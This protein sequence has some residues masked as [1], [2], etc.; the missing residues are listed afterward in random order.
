MGM[1]DVMNIKKNPKNEN[2]YDNFSFLVLHKPLSDA[3]SVCRPSMVT[4]LI[5]GNKD[6]YNQ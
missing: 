6:Q 2:D 5:A 3:F 4:Q 1:H